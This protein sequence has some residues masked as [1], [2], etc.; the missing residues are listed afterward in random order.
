MKTTKN[1][2]ALAASL[3]TLGASVPAANAATIVW[4]GGTGLFS[5]ANWTVNGTPNQNHPGN[6]GTISGNTIHATTVSGG[7]VNSFNNALVRSFNITNVANRDTLTISG[8]AV[9]NA[10]FIRVAA[11]DSGGAGTTEV[12]GNALGS[13][14]IIMQNGTINVS[15]ANGFQSS[16][17]FIGAINFTGAAGSASIVQTNNT[18]N[19]TSLASKVSATALSYFAIDGTMVSTGIAYNGTN[20]AAINAALATGGNVVGGRHF[21]IT[22]VSGTQTLTLIPEPSAA[23]L[24]GLG[25]L[26]LFS[27][28]R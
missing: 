20:L 13:P 23:L 16:V 25:M 10:D 22:D 11:Y 4:Q 3:L 7:T 12:S 8:G 17:N 1:Q 19:N 5:S 27:R 6:L 14:A 26:C 24:G 28:R 21:L 15:A 2:L 9:I 18:A